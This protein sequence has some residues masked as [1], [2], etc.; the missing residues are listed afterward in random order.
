MKITY[1]WE[2]I[3]D[4]SKEGLDKELKEGLITAGVFMHQTMGF[5]IEVFIDKLESMENKAE[6]WLFYLNFRNRHPNAFRSNQHTLVD[7]E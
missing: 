2:D 7:K 4:K 1:K 6:Q 5:P 3:P